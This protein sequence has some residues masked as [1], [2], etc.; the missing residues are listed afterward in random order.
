MPGIYFTLCNCDFSFSSLHWRC[1][2]ITCWRRKEEGEVNRRNRT[3]WIH[4]WFIRRICNSESS[5]AIC[6]H[7]WL[8]TLSWSNGCRKGLTVVPNT[9]KI[10]GNRWS[11]IAQQHLMADCG[12][13]S[14]AWYLG[15]VCYKIFGCILMSKI[16]T[17][18]FTLRGFYSFSWNVSYE[19][20]YAINWNLGI[21][22]ILVVSWLDTF[23]CFLWH[24]H[25]HT[26]TTIFIFTLEFFLT[27]ACT[28]E[29]WFLMMGY[30]SLNDRR[31][32]CAHPCVMLIFVP[33]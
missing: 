28:G 15:L 16:C 4:L 8:N 22:N 33:L 2:P 27:H 14:G 5:L 18:A 3:K 24:S 19:E 13:E 10:R 23:S 1:Q 32:K 12:F 25:L 11:I 29:S 7:H 6:S 21:F 31:G 30:M 20:L 9:M 26:D 17:K